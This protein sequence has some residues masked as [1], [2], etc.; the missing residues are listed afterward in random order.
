MARCP[1]ARR[2]IPPPSHIV[3][4]QTRS[5]LTQYPPRGVAGGCA[6]P[7]PAGRNSNTD[8]IAAAHNVP[9]PR[10]RMPAPL[11]RF[12]LAASPSAAVEQ[13]PPTTRPL[14][15]Q[16]SELMPHIAE[17]Q[18]LSTVNQFADLQSSL[19]PTLDDYLENA[20]RRAVGRNRPGQQRR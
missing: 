2:K 20:T 15:G 1:G 12:R 13:I 8:L 17:S 5:T 9:Q 7:I 6:H 11:I 16:L 10:P 18:P 14:Y 3:G 4:A 19:S